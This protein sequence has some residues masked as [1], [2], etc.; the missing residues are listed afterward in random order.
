MEEII[1]HRDNLIRALQFV[2]SARGE[3]AETRSGLSIEPNVGEKKLRT[4]A[5]LVPFILRNSGFTVL[6]TKRSEG[7]TDHAGQ[8]SFPG[9]CIDQG[10]RTLVDTAKRETFEEVGIAERAVEVITTLASVRTATGFIIHPIVGLVDS[11]VQ[12]VTNPSEVAQ[13]FEVPLT[14]LLRAENYQ[15]ELIETSVGL[16]KYETIR[17]N[18][19]RIWGATASIIAQFRKRIDAFAQARVNG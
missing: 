7:L 5:V 4:A 9:G 12:L 17:Y 10:D 11:S 2:P 19:H 8:I 6:F 15:Q 14:Y 16:Q 18:K 1:G 3:L 13:V